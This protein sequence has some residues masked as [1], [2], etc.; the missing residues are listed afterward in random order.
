MRRETQQKNVQ[1]LIQ[2]KSKFFLFI[3]KIRV[4]LTIGF[5]IPV[6]FL[7]FTGFFSYSTASKGMIK[8]YEQST[9]NAIMMAQ[10]YLDVG[11]E[12]TKNQA[13]EIVSNENISNYT[14]GMYAEDNIKQSM[15][16]TQLYYE[17]ETLASNN[18]FIKDI[19][20]IT[21][22]NLNLISTAAPEGTKGFY[23]EFI[24][25]PEGQSLLTNNVIDTWSSSHAVID[26]NMALKDQE[27]ALYYAHS[28]NNGKAAVV[29]DINNKI[30]QDALS[31]LNLGEDTILSFVTKEGKEVTTSGK[32]TFRFAEQEFYSNKSSSGEDSLSRY[33]KVNGK[34]FLYMN[35]KSNLSGASICALVP[36]AKVMA[37]ANEIKIVTIVLIVL[38]T[39]IS[40]SIGA[41]IMFGI[42]RNISRIT[43]RLSLVSKGDLTVSFDH[44]STNEFGILSQEIMQTITNTKQVIENAQGV[45]SYVFNST[46]QL[47]DNCMVLSKHSENISL[48]IEDINLGINQQSED[49]GQCLMQMDGLSTKIMTVSEN[50]NNI[51]NIADESKVYIKK[52]IVSMEKLSVCSETTS[53]ITH[54][55]I[56]SNQQLETKLGLIEQFVSLINEISNQT[57]LLALNASIEAARAGVYGRG[58]TVVAQEIKKLANDSLKAVDEITKT[59]TQIK[60]Q[61]S[62]TLNIA[63]TAGSVVNEQ[64]GTLSDTIK[65]LDKMNECI[66]KLLHNFYEVGNSVTS[67][68]SDREGTLSAIES[69]SSV[70]E[71][72]AAASCV[73]N[74]T[75]K[76][77]L[78]YVED[79][80]NNSAN[81][82]SKSKELSDII[83]QFKI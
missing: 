81:L 22:D 44:H 49:A 83:H 69:I 58:F 65:A 52:G 15:L 57:N 36:K 74:E 9:Q 4:Q 56:E 43:K 23:Q 41:F 40:G 71:E 38:A 53:K 60:S 63:L 66:E 27:Y 62:D 70:S 33:V 29:I 45:N 10:Q 55:V 82:Q 12:F 80:K 72:T 61:S 78:K 48:A 59:V 75:A 64:E 68:G 32:E 25:S 76:E 14:Y 35:F 24:D 28:T 39:L 54:Q 6:F 50:L 26:K 19:H 21:N 8:N 7:V 77:Q 13:L 51:E 31:K 67:M 11:F 42:I 16:Y 18:S 30:V 1:T 46:N 20:I 17:L 5:I 2:L 34:E 3:S 79:L 47:L 37:S 73:V